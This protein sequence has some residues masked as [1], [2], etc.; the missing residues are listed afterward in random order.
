MERVPEEKIEILSVDLLDRH[1]ACVNALK[2]TARSLNLEFEWHYLLDL[3]W[4]LDHLGPL[5]GRRI[6]DAGAG[7]GL[8]QWYLA[9]QGAKVLSVDRSSRADLPL[10]APLDVTRETGL[11][12]LHAHDH[13]RLAVAETDGLARVAAETVTERD[14]GKPEALDRDE[15]RRVVEGR[16]SFLCTGDVEAFVKYMRGEVAK[17]GRHQAVRVNK[18][19]C[20]SQCGHGPMMIVYPD[21][22]WYAGVKR[23][24]LDDI[25]QSALR[26]VELGELVPAGIGDIRIAEASRGLVVAGLQAQQLLPHARPA[27]LVLALGMDGTDVHQQRV[28]A[29]VPARSI[30]AEL[31]TVTFAVSASRASTARCF[32]P[33]SLSGR[34]PRSTSTGPRTRISISSLSGRA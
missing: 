24:D 33:A 15:P 3:T 10:L 5:K 9:D 23:E 32:G 22:V 27:V 6:M 16:Y 2:R 1:R 26:G 25:V 18:A 19:G 14:T 31:E 17:A 28:V 20:F 11:V 8:I 7:T 4:I 30:A 21:N 12:A 29:D 34:P 13:L